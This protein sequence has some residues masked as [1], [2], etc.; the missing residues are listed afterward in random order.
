MRL[1]PCHVQLAGGHCQ[2][3]AGAAVSAGGCALLLCVAALEALWWGCKSG[4]RA[5]CK[6]GTSGNLL[7]MSAVADDHFVFL[8]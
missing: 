2:A 4:T 6:G 5:C 3:A 1:K 8:G 7:M